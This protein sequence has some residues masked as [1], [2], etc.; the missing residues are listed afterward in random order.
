MDYFPSPKP[1]PIKVV[2]Y[3]KMPAGH[4]NG[5]NFQ[6]IAISANQGG[7]KHT[8]QNPHTGASSQHQRIT[9]P[10]AIVSY[11]LSGGVYVM[12][13]QR[14]VFKRTMRKPCCEPHCTI[15]LSLP[16][17]LLLSFRSYIQFRETPTLYI[18]L[19]PLHMLLLAPSCPRSTANTFPTRRPQVFLHCV[20]NVLPGQQVS[21]RRTC[22]E[23]VV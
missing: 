5:T 4:S 1:R 14:G 20:T 11:V 2:K 13:V 18:V 8:K 22:V 21:I 10:M 7:H 9:S 23:A 12:H 19:H 16:Y 17:L 3:P 15:R 6:V